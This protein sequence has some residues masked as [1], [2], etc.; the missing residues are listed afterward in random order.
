MIFTLIAGEKIDPGDFL[1]FDAETGKVVKR[2]GVKA[3]F[4]AVDSIQK[5]E[6]AELDVATGQISKGHA[7]TPPI[8]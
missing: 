6:L 1:V 5:D 4:L 2:R 3:E 8:S 7:H